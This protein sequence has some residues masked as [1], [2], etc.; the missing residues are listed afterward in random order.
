VGDA[1]SGAVYLYRL[2]PERGV[3]EG[4][5]VNVLPRFDFAEWVGDNAAHSFHL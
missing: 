3:L 1:V 4:R 5:E 2:A